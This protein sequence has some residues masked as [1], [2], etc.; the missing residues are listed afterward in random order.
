MAALLAPVCAAAPREDDLASLRAQ[1]QQQTDPIKRAK[2]F[3]RLG[4]ALLAE[5]KK[6][7]TAKQYERVPALLIEYRDSAAIAVS[8]LSG[9]GRDAEKHA[10]GFRELEMHLRRALRQVNDIVYGMPLDDREPLLG[11]QHDIEDLDN[12]LVKALFPRGPQPPGAPPSKGN[13]HP[14][15]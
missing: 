11:P 2:L 6:Q 1:F 10:S 5:M 14:Q 7:E 4:T 8:A 9:A 13:P 3:P 12:K 15:G